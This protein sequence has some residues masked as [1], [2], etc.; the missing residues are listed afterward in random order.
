MPRDSGWPP[1]IVYSLNVDLQWGTPK[2]DASGRYVC[3]S[4]KLTQF[5]DAVE[6]RQDPVGVVLEESLR[7]HDV[8]ACGL[9]DLN[10]RNPDAESPAGRWPAGAHAELDRPAIQ[11]DGG[12]GKLV[13]PTRHRS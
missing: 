13:C 7:A 11:I 1:P 12:R 3:V 6:L 4:S 8:A 9:D 2:H 5:V 10:P